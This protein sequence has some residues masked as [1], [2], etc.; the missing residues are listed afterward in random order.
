MGKKTIF[1]RRSG[2]ITFCKPQVKWSSFWNYFILSD[3]NHKDKYPPK[4]NVWGKKC[5]FEFGW[6]VSR[7][8]DINT[9]E[10][11]YCNVLCDSSVIAALVQVEIVAITSPAQQRDLGPLTSKSLCGDR[12]DLLSKLQ[13]YR[14][15]SW[16]AA[17]VYS[18][19]F[20][21]FFPQPSPGSEPPSVSTPWH[22]SNQKLDCSQPLWLFWEFISLFRKKKTTFLMT[23]RCFQGPVLLSLKYYFNALMHF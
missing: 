14:K 18:L 1:R 21:C 2:T 11:N 13:T 7:S 12:W 4:I 19:V 20:L 16:C 3:V 23:L 9:R 5:S 6:M 15:I 17:A 22:V 8:M 10:Q